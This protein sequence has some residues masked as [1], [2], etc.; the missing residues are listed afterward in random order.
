MSPSSSLKYAPIGA[1][2]LR[3]NSRSVRA[4]SILAVPLKPV[5][6]IEEFLHPLPL[7]ALAI[8]GVNDHVLKGAGLLHGDITGKLSDITGLFFF[9][10]L[11]TAT[12]RC[13]V[14]L[15][16]WRREPLTRTVLATAI[17]LTAALF[18]ALKTITPFVLWFERV[19]PELDP[20]GL[21]G[22]V[23]VTMDLTDLWTLPV[24]WL[25][26]RHGRRFA[27]PS[28]DTSPAQKPTMT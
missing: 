1:N 15:L 23:D 3:R 2:R 18:T 25:T 12:W 21:V 17:G 10:L 26:W 16:R 7:L 24:L 11:L 6:P 8:L 5:L 22:H 20:L 19:T 4:T 28:T 9:P 13:V 14:S 27:L